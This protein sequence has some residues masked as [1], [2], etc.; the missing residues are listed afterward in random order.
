MC[1]YFDVSDKTMKERLLNRGKTSGRA[2]DNEETIGLRLKT[3]HN[4]TKPVISHYDKQ[5]KLKVI[6]CEKEASVVFDGIKKILDKEEGFEFEPS[7]KLDLSP[8]KEATVLF[9]I[10]GPGS[11]KGTQCE[12]MVAK[13]DYTHI[14]SGDL[15]RA[16][17][18]S[19]SERG[20]R[21]EKVMK[22]GLLVPNNV[23]LDMIKEKMLE[24]VKKGSKGFLVDGYPRAVEQGVEFETEIVPCAI[25]LN[26]VASDR[27]MK[28]RLLNRGKTSG[29]SDDNEAA[30]AQRLKVFHE[31]T[32]PVLEYYEKAGKL[33]N[34][35]GEATADQAFAECKKHID[36]FNRDTKIA[37]WK[38]HIK[39]LD[40]TVDQIVHCVMN[41]ASRG[42]DIKQNVA[43]TIQ[44][45]IAE[46]IAT[47]MEP[48]AES[49]FDFLEYDHLEIYKGK[50]ERTRAVC[51]GY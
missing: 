18:A 35:N 22:R 24:E 33:R 7:R 43:S 30:V 20:K 23:V 3:F 17:V 34:V 42:K 14:S 50:S 48:N 1:L 32:A 15:L 11:G 39:E 51:G 5:G 25:V 9:V 21:L 47:E 45:A 40:D 19:G 29:R 49:G 2:D 13:Y 31:S 44:S 46:L 38:D 37:H 8:L 27:T 6:N 16:E 26:M 4:E 36:K 41:N 28:D 10:G 12:K